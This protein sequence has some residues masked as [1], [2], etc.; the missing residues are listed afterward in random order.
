VVVR[1][2]HLAVLERLVLVAKAVAVAAL[3]LQLWLVQ[4]VLVD[5]LLVVV[6]VVVLL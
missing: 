1:L 2:V 3:Q 6:A 4:A 5:S